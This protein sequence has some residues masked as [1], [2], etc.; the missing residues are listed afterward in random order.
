MLPNLGV[1]HPQVVHFAI[2]LLIVG[3]L[4]RLASFLGARFSWT[5][6]TATTLIV[7]GA[8]A[9]FAAVKTGD[10]AHAPVER[11][12]GVRS[13]V[14]EHEEW[15]ERVRNLFAIIALIELA[16]LA[17]NTRPE[18]QKLQ[19]GMRVA[20]GLIGVMGIFFVYEAGE[21]G[22][23]IVYDHAGGVGTHSGNPRDVQNLLMAGLYN[24][25]LAQRKAGNLEEAARLSNELLRVR[26]TDPTVKLFAAQSL[27]QD[28]NDA[29]GALDA[30]SQMSPAATGPMRT[31]VPMM[32][33]R[34]YMKLGLK[35][36]ANAEMAP[37]KEQMQTNPRMKAFA[38]SLR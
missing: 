30:L 19:K 20:S 4:F 31:Q 11:M 34:A 35:D 10:D 17:L 23:K 13:A 33:A 36:S 15:G 8:I 6:P 2:V 16:A 27:L 32:R 5:N 38:D 29:R 1:Y 21:H 18:R 7:A 22:G 12:P 28:K 3:V 25:A 26:P 37:F 14:Q 9:A 24:S